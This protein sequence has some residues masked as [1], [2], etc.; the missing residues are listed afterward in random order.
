MNI[1]RIAISAVHLLFG[2]VVVLTAGLF[3]GLSWGNIPS[4]F[5]WISILLLLAAEILAYGSILFVIRD[6]RRARTAVPAALPYIVISVLYAAAVLFHIVVFWQIAHVSFQAY[7]IIQF[8]TLGTA[9]A[10]LS[11]AAIQHRFVKDQQDEQKT[12]TDL[13]KQ[14]QGILQNALYMLQARD[15][16]HEQGLKAKLAH[17]TDK[18][19]YS[20]PVSHPSL[21]PIEESLFW[22]SKELEKWLRASGGAE[23]GTASEELPDQL[24]R[25]MDYELEKRNRQ[26][27]ALK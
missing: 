13:F 8:V 25:D 3:L 17:L 14:I 10:A 7:L 11:I 20:D 16:P 9:V 27:I 5:W 22:Q 21:L 1:Q 19:R 6:G 18:A 23:G 2:T 12:K 26:H 24:I 4:R 15:Y